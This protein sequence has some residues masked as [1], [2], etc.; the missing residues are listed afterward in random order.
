M[1]IIYTEDQL[2]RETRLLLT[3]VA[4]LVDNVVQ[5]GAGIRALGLSPDTLEGDRHFEETLH[6]DDL[7]DL[8]R[9][10]VWHVVRRIE[11]YVKQ[12][13]PPDR[14]GADL[15]WLQNALHH[16]F[17]T[18]VLQ[19]YERERASNPRE[20][21]PGRWKEG[22]GDV[23]IGYFHRGIL[24][25]LVELASARLKVD[26]GEPLTMSEI[27]TLL[28]MRE[29][30]VVTNAHRKKFETYE[31]DNR[32]YSRPENVLPW[33]IKNGYVPTL[34]SGSPS[35]AASPSATNDDV[36]FVP[37]AHDNTWFSPD[38]RINGRY[39]I[40]NK[41][42]ERRFTDYFDALREVN[43]LPTPRWR[44]KTQDG[45]AG[46]AFGVR[47]DRVPRAEIDRVLARLTKTD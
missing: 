14:V 46:I 37:T 35:T 32:R 40:G 13:A 10:D 22:A 6:P 45:I 41:G 44:T 33:M 38:C 18:E 12:Q 29:A 47:F 17:S 27:A 2:L 8:E 7:V 24:Q 26:Q 28:D 5:D 20:N 23:E 39:T 34:D 19:R 30:T 3:S 11:R 36:L 16:A 42:E 21:I 25:N 9:F 4:C 43:R 31:E 1:S 15:M